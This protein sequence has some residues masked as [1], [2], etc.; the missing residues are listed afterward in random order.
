MSR[1]HTFVATC[2][3][4]LEPVLREELVEIGVDDTHVLRGAVRFRA[5]LE[6]GLRVLIWTRV[7][8]R[9]LA[10]LD[11]FPCP[12]ADALY[13]GVRSIDWT[14]HLE[15]EGSL[16]VDFVGGSETIRHSQFGAY[17][18]KDA[19]V[20]GIRA[21]TGRRPS[22]DLRDPDLR[23]NV[24]LG[25]GFA[26][27]SIDMAGTPLHERGAGR[28]AGKA[29]LKET[30]AAAALRLAGWHERVKADQGDGLWLMDPLCG[31]GTFLFEGLGMALDRAPGLHRDRWGIDG[32]RVH[33]EGLFAGVLAEA[34]ER[35]RAGQDRRVRVV[36]RDRL[37][38][39][40][41]GAEDNAQAM[42]LTAFVDLAQG[43]LH[44]AVPPLGPPGL[45][46]TNPPYGERM[47]EAV[48]A[49]ATMAELGNVLRHNFL[50]WSAAVFAGSIALSKRIGLRPDARVPIFNG[51]L[52][53]RLLL[54]SI[55]SKPVEGGGPGWKGRGEAEE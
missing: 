12:D 9:V 31:S 20:D 40:I 15:P 1:R 34:K 45:L 2:S 48:E 4:G 47:A 27:V 10:V 14:R 25:G 11:R 36:G 21:K 54:L 37:H 43:E 3:R 42:G 26:T 53:C 18:T 52:D 38:A 28:R 32:W 55:S 30:L 8:S 5:S 46:I 13:D 51:P 49:Q 35:Q 22:V 6:A 50:G 23:I 17:R 44:D 29:P 33:D 19:V 24:H 16:A 7:A 41:K 39:A